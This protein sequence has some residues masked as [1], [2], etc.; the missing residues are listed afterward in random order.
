[1]IATVTVTNQCPHCGMDANPGPMHDNVCPAQLEIR[2]R[3]QT[4]G[5]VDIDWELLEVFNAAVELRKK[6]ARE[7]E[8]K[9]KNR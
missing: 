3:Q 8:A 1:M 5:P 6:E 9:K 7:K 2:R 4:V